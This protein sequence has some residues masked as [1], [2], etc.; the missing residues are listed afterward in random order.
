M[1]KQYNRVMLGRGGRFS[2]EC[3]KGGFIGADFDIPGDLTNQ[4][5][6]NWRDFNKKFIPVYL[7]NNPEGI[8]QRIEWIVKQ[9]KSKPAWDMPKLQEKMCPKTIAKH[10]AKQWL[11]TENM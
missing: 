2:E 3:H 4:L 6:E 8:V 7:E 10:F 5:P 1:A 9:G 11:S